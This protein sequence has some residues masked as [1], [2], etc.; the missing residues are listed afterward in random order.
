MLTIQDVSVRL[1][2]HMVL[3]RASA[4]LPPKAR[5][6]LVGRNGSGKS[7]LLKV[8]SG[9]IQPDSG[10]IEVPKGVR[11]GYVAQEAPSGSAPAFEP[12]LAAAHERARLLAAA[13]TETDPAR[14]AEVHERLATIGAHAAPARAARILAGMG[15][16]EAMRDGPLDSLSG[17][18]RMRVALASILFAEPDV[19]LLDEPSNHLDLEATL[20]LESFLV[21]YR[22]TVLLVSHEQ[23]GRAHV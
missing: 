23:I 13:D 3:D 11:V 20:W 15:F 9:R 14:L 17:G 18:W 1:G 16:D 19:L 6:G 12:V 5:V 22:G 7:T 4:S 10:T 21:R 8:V 2:G